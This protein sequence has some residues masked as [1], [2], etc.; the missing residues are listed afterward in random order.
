MDYTRLIGAEEMTR[1]A[2]TI[3]RAAEDM[4]VAA[5]TI[6]SAL[7]RHQQFLDDWLARLEAALNPPAAAGEE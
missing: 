5:L 3:R 4:E 1:A 7:R 6:D 2:T